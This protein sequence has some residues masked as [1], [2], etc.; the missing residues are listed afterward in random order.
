M[1]V[2]KQLN[3]AIESGEVQ[4]GSNKSIESL[5]NGNPKLVLLSRNCPRK[6][7]EA[8]T[9]YCR[10]AGVPVVTLKENSV[11]V[12]SGVGKPYP[13]SAVTVLDEGESTILEAAQ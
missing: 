9:Y 8:I 10:L 2:K 1:D 6:Q 3:V 4:I 12:G 13:I 11:E 5:L 7:R